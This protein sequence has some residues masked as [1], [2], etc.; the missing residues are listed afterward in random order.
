[1]NSK[2]W[3]AFLNLSILV[4]TLLGIVFCKMEI[5]RMGYVVWKLAR[6]EKVAQD[7]KRLEMLTYTKL[8]RPE[9]IENFAEKYFDLKKA[10]SH[11]VIHLEDVKDF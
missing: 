1:M 8:T 5:R 7:M 6:E 2:R 11:Q 4:L 10:D 3:S 9:R